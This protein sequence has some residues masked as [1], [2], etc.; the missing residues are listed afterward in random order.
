MRYAIGVIG[1]TFASAAFSAPSTSL[2]QQVRHADERFWQAFNTCDRARMAL[3]FTPDVEF[4]HDKTGATFTRAAV[5]KSLMDGPC[6]TQ[7]LHVRRELVAN[8]TSFDPVPGYGAILTGRHR[9]YARRDG[10]TE[11]LDGEARFAIIW[12]MVRGRPL[13]RRVLSFAH[14]PVSAAVETRA[15]VVPVAD[16]QRYVGRYATAKGDIVVTMEDDRL[17]LVS[18]GLST[19]LIAITSTLFKA[20]QRPLDFEFILNGDKVVKLLVRENGSFVVD[21]TRTEK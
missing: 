15:A 16:L 7:G 11:R 6:G 17:H 1:A 21:G 12:Q 19:D 2:E 20:Q 10:E 18:G 5:V 3:L 9:F 8:S 4:Y 14:G 13:I